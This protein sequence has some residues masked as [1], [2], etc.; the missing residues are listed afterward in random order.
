[1]SAGPD[2]PP[3]FRSSGNRP[4][5]GPTEFGESDA[6]EFP[7]TGFDT[8]V[9]VVDDALPRWLTANATAVL[10]VAVGAHGLVT[11]GPALPDS[12]GS[13]HPGIGTMPLPILSAPRDDLPAVRRKA[14]EQDI[15]VIDFN[16]AAKES[17]V[18]DE[19]RER[20]LSGASGYLGLALIGRKKAV[21]SITGNLRSLR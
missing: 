21:R 8:C 3:S 9:L 6:G 4:Q 18:Y 16:D 2:R 20:L 10:G 15:M 7:P 14:L 19:Y 12:E 1:M 13:W 17:R 5:E 11:A